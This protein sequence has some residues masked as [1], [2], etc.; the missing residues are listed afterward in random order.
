MVVGILF[1]AGYIIWFKFINPDANNA[2]HWLFGISPEGIGSIGMLIN[3]IVSYIVS[4]LFPQPPEKIKHLVE[5]IR[6]PR[7][8]GQVTHMH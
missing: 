6:I 8:A 5:D 7:G 2:D 1:T 3:F 4:L